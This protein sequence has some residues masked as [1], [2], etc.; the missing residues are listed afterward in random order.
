MTSGYVLCFAVDSA[1]AYIV[2]LKLHAFKSRNTSVVCDFCYVLCF[3]VH[4]AEAHIVTIKLHAFKSRNTRV[5]CGFWLSTD[6]VLCVVLRS[7]QC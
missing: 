4:S 3:A 2:T 5:V 7:T 1:E 6:A